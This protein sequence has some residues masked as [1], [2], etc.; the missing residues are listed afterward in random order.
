M[1]HIWGCSIS[2]IHQFCLSITLCNG[3]VLH[4][5]NHLDIN[6]ATVSNMQECIHL[7]RFFSQKILS[8]MIT[9]FEFCRGTRLGKTHNLMSHQISH[10]RCWLVQ[11]LLCNVQY[12]SVISKIIYAMEQNNY[13]K[14]INLWK[15]LWNHLLHNMII[16]LQYYI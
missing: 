8:E 14:N 11:V 10:L 12:F 2:H 15:V 1:Y 13:Q 4:L 5:K 6:I 9:M 7:A 3:N 16:L